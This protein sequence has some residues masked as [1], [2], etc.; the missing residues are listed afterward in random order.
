[1]YE[2]WFSSSFQRF[3]PIKLFPLVKP[4]SW[5]IVKRQKLRIGKPA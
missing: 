5:G 4:V 3:V 2:F 1:M